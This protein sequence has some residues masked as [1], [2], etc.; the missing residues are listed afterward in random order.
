MNWKKA[1]GFGALIW[2]VMFIVISILVG[3]GLV[4]SNDSGWSL[5]SIVTLAVTVLVTY[6][7]AR[8]VAPVSYSQAIS[9]GLVFAV[10]GIILDY[11][12]STRFAP[13][14]FSSL[15]YWVSYLILALVPLSVVNKSAVPVQ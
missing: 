13:N 11:F 4:T 5:W 9:Y 6:L 2:V 3:Y 12:I 8:N 1:L 10:V 14:I 15:S 7:A